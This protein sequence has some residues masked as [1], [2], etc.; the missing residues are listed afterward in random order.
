MP[1]ELMSSIGSRRSGRFE[2]RRICEPCKPSGWNRRV[3]AHAGE[4][5]ERWAARAPHQRGPGW[6]KMPQVRGVYM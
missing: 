4:H 3:L 2:A 1:H 5:R 6:L